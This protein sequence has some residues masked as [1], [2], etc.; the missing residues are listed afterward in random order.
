MDSKTG[1]RNSLLDVLRFD[2]NAN[3]LAS[4]EPGKTRGSHFK[5]LHNL[6]YQVQKKI[7]GLSEQLTYCIAKTE[8]LTNGLWVLTCKTVLECAKVMSR[9]LY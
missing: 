9:Q 7:H 4:T 5:I 8:K 2:M 3:S 1:I 6:F